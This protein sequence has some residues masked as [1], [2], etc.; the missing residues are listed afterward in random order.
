MKGSTV[1]YSARAA[2]LF[3]ALADQTRL[4]ILDELKDGERCVCELTDRLQAGQ[5]RLSFHLKVLK[6]AGL[7]QDRRD[8][9]WMYYTVNAEGI[10]ELDELVAS[11]KQS[12][13]V[14]RAAGCC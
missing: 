5:S 3:H 11:F 8:G 13:K 9:R 2:E 6:E 7:I 12:R 4:D 10:A 14:R 1:K